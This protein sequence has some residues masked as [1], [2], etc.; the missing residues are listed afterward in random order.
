MHRHDLVQ[1]LK[2]Y[3]VIEQH[4]SETRDRFLDFVE[5]SPQCFE[6]SLSI[7][8]VTGS[9]WIVNP[10]RDRFLLTFHSKLNIWLQLGGHA[11]GNPNVLD[12]ALREAREE[13]GLDNIRCLT[14]EIFDLDI[15][16]IPEHKEVAEHY[17]YDARFLFEADD[18]QPLVISDESHDLRWLRSEEI[19]QLTQEESILRMLRKSP[20]R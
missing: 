13:S 3:T 5:S 7:G 14:P 6:R 16:R 15:H 17:H 12:V 1:R 19:R 20:R 8:H 2:S 18:A 9:A 4:D 10:T 11:D